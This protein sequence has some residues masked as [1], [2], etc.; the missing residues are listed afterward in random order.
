MLKNRRIGLSQSGVVQAF[1]KFGRR[2]VMEWCDNAY[3]H[4]KELDAEYSDW[5]CI[6]KSVRMTSIKPSGTVSLLTVLLPVF[7][8]PKMNTIFVVFRFAADS[9]MLQPLA[10]AGYKIEPIIT[11]QTLCV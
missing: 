11:L 7:T 5:L 2:Q 3:E 1:N 10:A 9:D 6:P 4:V 8:T